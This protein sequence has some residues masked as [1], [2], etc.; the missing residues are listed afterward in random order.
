M[1]FFVSV[2]MVSCSK[3]EPDAEHS[4]HLKDTP[5]NGTSATVFGLMNDS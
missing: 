2:G 4:A 1:M 3:A 5:V